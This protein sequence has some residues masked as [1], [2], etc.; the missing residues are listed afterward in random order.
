MIVAAELVDEMACRGLIRK[1]ACART[2]P[3][4]R[5]RHVPVRRVTHGDSRSVTGQPV[6][7]LTGAAAGPPVAATSLQAVLMSLRGTPCG[8]ENGAGLPADAGISLGV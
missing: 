8:R 6:W 3:T 4:G 7:L 5:A 1:Q 2:Q